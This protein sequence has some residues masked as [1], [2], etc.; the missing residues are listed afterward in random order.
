MDDLW[1]DAWTNTAADRDGDD[2]SREALSTLLA[3]ELKPAGERAARIRRALLAWAHPDDED[4]WT[5]D[6]RLEDGDEW[7]P[8]NWDVLS[9]DE[10]LDRPPSYEVERVEQLTEPIELAFVG[11][12]NRGFL[13]PR[14]KP[15]H[16]H[17]GRLEEGLQLTEALEPI[18]V[19]DTP[20]LGN[21]TEAHRDIIAYLTDPSAL[22][23]A[24]D[25]DIDG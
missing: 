2:L 8:D 11:E 13:P 25:V 16:I 23:E 5:W 1:H 19:S 3:L 22:P 9:P 14:A 10:L 12:P 20:M 21:L 18:D 24:V 4:D 6:E 7:V 17:V 15:D